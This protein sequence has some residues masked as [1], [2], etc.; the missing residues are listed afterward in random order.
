M[1][2]ENVFS[3]HQS[4]E[5][6]AVLTAD[7]RAA[8]DAARAA[9]EAASDRLRAQEICVACQAFFE[10]DPRVQRVRLTG[11]FSEHIDVTLWMDVEKEGRTQEISFEVPSVSHVDNRFD[12]SV[13]KHLSK[14]LQ[15]TL[16]N[17]RD[18]VERLNDGTL[19]RNVSQAWSQH[20]LEREW[21][22]AALPALQRALATPELYDRWKAEQEHAAFGTALPDGETLKRGPRL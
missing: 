4:F 14:T 16:R 9:F 15:A 20:A 6:P 1:N 22:R 21:T 13:R 12:A 7:N 2:Q 3:S 10:A 19:P 11:S 17:L 8:I 18:D 5:L